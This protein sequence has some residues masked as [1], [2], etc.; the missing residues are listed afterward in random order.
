MQE[1]IQKA[2]TVQDTVYQNRYLILGIILTGTFMAMLDG[3]MVSIGLPAIT[4]QY[5]V[6]IVQSQWVITGYLLTTTGLFIFFGKVSSYTGKVK[7]FLVGWAIFG[8]SSL[9]C[10]LAPGLN[11]LIASRV[12]QGIGGSMVMSISTALIYLAFPP[13]ER[14]RAMG[15]TALVFGGA[16]LIGPGLG[17]FIVDHLGWEYMFFVNVPICA[18]LLVIGLRYMKIPEETAERLEI[19]W[20]GAATLFLAVAAFLM[21]CTEVAKDLQV[22]GMIVTYA[23]VCALSVL[24]FLW[25]ESRCARPLLDLSIF[26]NRRF[27]LP[28]LSLM[29]IYM[30]IAAV[31]TLAPFFFQGAMGY[32][33]S[34]VGYISMVT[35]L[36]LML[37]AP[38]GGSL[39]DR[40]HW[41][42]QAAG[43]MLLYAAGMLLLGCGFLV[44]SF[45]LIIAAFVVRGVANGL[46]TSPNSIEIMGSVPREKISVASSVQTT[47]LYLAMIAGVT[48][49]AILVTFGLGRDGYH[50][51]VLAAGSLLPGVV[52]TIM[53]L[54]AALC[55]LAAGLSV[56]RNFR[57]AEMIKT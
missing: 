11:E 4:Q 31:N 3:T 42:Y 55:V 33:T 32:S 47:A 50:G 35:P 23:A 12:A 26:S 44:M 25:H 24:V 37:A 28:I 18:A 16:A 8:L 5:H 29:I 49:S 22:T 10:G 13:Q 20:I 52:G 38:L 34:D 9:A 21:L 45:W 7:L 41:K 43:G 40:R 2:S 53:L 39:Y 14:G 17:G 36:L 19:D 54:S 30:A 48:F 1:S 27:T 51:P 15:F 6:D 46:Y 56:A 57:Q